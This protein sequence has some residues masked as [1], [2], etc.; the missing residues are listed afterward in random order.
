MENREQ[1]KVVLGSGTIK[2]WWGQTQERNWTS[3]VGGK[4]GDFVTS[5]QIHCWATLV[6]HLFPPQGIA[7][8]P[9]LFQ[10]QASGRSI[11]GANVTLSAPKSDDRLIYCILVQD[12]L[13]GKEVGMRECRYR[14]G[15][16][17]IIKMAQCSCSLCLLVKLPLLVLLNTVRHDTLWE[18]SWPLRVNPLSSV[19]GVSWH[20]PDGISFR[21]CGPY[22]LYRNSNQCVYNTGLK[23]VNFLMRLTY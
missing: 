12:V 15:E 6:I 19:L 4:E 9:S 1:F 8:G 18:P 22:G 13:L 16:G 21:I 11:F 2:I 3:H 17:I 7:Q 20:C 23:N 10:M 14:M 5:Y